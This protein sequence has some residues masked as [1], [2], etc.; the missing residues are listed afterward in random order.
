M[1]RRQI[2]LSAAALVAAGM[3]R[4]ALADDDHAE[5]M[6]HHAGAP[7]NAALLAAASDCVRTGQI[8]LDHCLQL[9]AQGDN[10]T[11]ACARS[12]SQVV[13]ACQALE[14]LAAL[15]SKY[16]AADRNLTSKA[17]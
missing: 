17:A 1:E 15:N 7:A 11:A 9:F 10:A 12:V 14:Q 8:C 6:H 13:P 3:G 16:V 4:A 2:L 5:H